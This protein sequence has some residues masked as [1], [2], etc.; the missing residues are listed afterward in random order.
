MTCRQ[1]LKSSLKLSM[2]TERNLRFMYILSSVHSQK[3]VSW[4]GEACFSFSLMLNEL[5][6]VLCALAVT[7]SKSQDRSFSEDPIPQEGK[8]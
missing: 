5:D 8:E 6:S 2:L 4:G 3:G 1:K 7:K